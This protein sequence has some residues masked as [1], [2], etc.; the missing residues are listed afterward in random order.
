MD[1]QWFFLES[2]EKMLSVLL[3]SL[4]FVTKDKIRFT[5]VYSD[6]LRGRLWVFGSSQ[7]QTNVKINKLEDLGEKNND[8]NESEKQ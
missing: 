4:A 6:D 5:V 2:C 7:A 1:D 8:E 3:G